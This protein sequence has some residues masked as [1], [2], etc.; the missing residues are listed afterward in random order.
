MLAG[1]AKFTLDSQCGGLNHKGTDFASHALSSFL[2]ASRARGWSAANLYVDLVAAFDSVVREIVMGARLSP[3][4][5]HGRLSLLKLDED[6]IT[7]VM[8]YVQHGDVL[9]GRRGRAH[10]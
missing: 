2:E 5:L 4:A 10:C 6:V 3:A 8:S 9:E 1:I 7:A